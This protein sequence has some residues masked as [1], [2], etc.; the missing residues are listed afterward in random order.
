MTS[1]AED[2]AARAAQLFGRAREAPDDAALRAEIA[3]WRA[4]D[5]RHA[6]A[7]DVVER[8]WTAFDGLAS[9]PI[10]A[11][12]RRRALRAS[13]PRAAGWAVLAAASAAAVAG[14]LIWTPGVPPRPAPVAAPE[15]AAAPVQVAE[16]ARPAFEPAAVYRAS[17]GERLSIVLP[18]GSTLGLGGAAEV[19]VAYDG[20]RRLNAVRFGEATFEV[21]KDPRRPFVVEAGGRRITAHGTVFRVRVGGEGVSVALFEGTVSVEGR[22]SGGVEWLAPGFELVSRPEGPDAVRRSADARPDAGGRNSPAMD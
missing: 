21:A 11:N 17:D 18:D 8:G 10:V 3:A 13:R 2:L 14:V 19:A 16:A 12:L 15:P 7:Y 9:D 4:A 1:S 6:E 20:E 22:G 5:P